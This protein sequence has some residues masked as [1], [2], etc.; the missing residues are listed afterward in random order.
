[1]IEIV[2]QNISTHIGKNGLVSFKPSGISN[3]L[4]ILS[5]FG[6]STPINFVPNTGASILNHF[7]TSRAWYISIR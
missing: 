2:F 6:I 3:F 4:K 5:F 1:L 7:S